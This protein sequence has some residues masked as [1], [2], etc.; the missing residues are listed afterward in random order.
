[1]TIKAIEFAFIIC[2]CWN[3]MIFQDVF[4][5][6][7]YWLVNLFFSSNSMKIFFTNF[8]APLMISMSFLRTFRCSTNWWICCS[9]S[10]NS[11]WATFFS[12]STII[13]QL[14]IDWCNWLAA[15]WWPCRLFASTFFLWWVSQLPLSAKHQLQYSYFEFF[16]SGRLYLIINE[17]VD[18]VNC[19]GHY[20]LAQI[21]HVV[22]NIIPNGIIYNN[23]K[24]MKAPL[25][26]MHLSFP[27]APFSFALSNV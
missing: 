5:M 27:S 19:Q 20:L 25:V 2:C 17:K 21:P 14:L 18:A 26:D 8:K 10:M 12:S 4:N 24:L 13:P 15:Y 1:M 22:E 7:E 3:V 16:I 6:G 11:F 9:I 23:T